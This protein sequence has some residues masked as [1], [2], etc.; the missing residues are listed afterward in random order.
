MTLHLNNGIGA[1]LGDNIVVAAPFILQNGNVL[2]V[3]SATGT[4][5]GG[6]AGHNREKPLATLAQALTNAADHDRI[7]LLSG[8]EETVTNA[9]SVTKRVTIV[10]EGASGGLPTV[11]FTIDAAAQSLFDVS[12]DNVRLFNLWIE[13]N[14][15]A[16]SAAKIVLSGG[17][18]DGFWMR[19]CYLE[20][21]G[22]DDASVL[23]ISVGTDRVRIESCT[24][25]STATS[26][27]AQPHS[28]IVPAGALSDFVMRDVVISDGTVG[29]SN[30]W[31]FDASA[32]ALERYWIEN[33]SLLLGAEA[34]F[35]ASS[36]GH[37]AGLTVTGGGKVSI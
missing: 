15:Q 11:K 25:I 2:Y 20:A 33:L 13:E 3:D 37:I 8:H 10:G 1:D 5:A 30:I 23:S 32:D 35:H 9:Y 31:A 34:R 19:G 28:A 7:V 21:N 22:N 4:D 29:W 18:A 6:T 12:V 27:S 24:F 14:A 17:T 36:S 26:S 16:N